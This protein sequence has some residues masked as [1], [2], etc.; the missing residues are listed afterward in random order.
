MK[1]PVILSV[2]EGY[3]I[4]KEQ[5]NERKIMLKKIEDKRVYSWQEYCQIM[6]GKRSY[7]L[8]PLNKEVDSDKFGDEP[9]LAEFE[10]KEDV[11]PLYAFIK[12]LKLRRN[13][14]GD[15]KPD[16][17]N[18]DQSKFVIISVKNRIDNV[19]ND[20]LS[21]PMSFPTREMRDDFVKTFKHLLE[22][23]KPL[24]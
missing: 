3:E 12:L 7:F 15:W 2:P 21:R 10:D 24:L 13:W 23:A 5:S 18:E 22:I 1:E 20:I 19:V 14:V 8:H 16:W 4:D 17:T 9:A 6:K 11:K